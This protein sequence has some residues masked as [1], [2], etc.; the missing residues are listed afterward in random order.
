MAAPMGSCLTPPYIET[1]NAT[2]SA[3]L[4]SVLWG[5]RPQPPAASG[6]TWITSRTLIAST[7]TR[8]DSRRQLL[9][10]CAFVDRRSIARTAA[11]EDEYLG[12]LDLAQGGQSEH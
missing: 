6:S 5:S 11:E 8:V 1:T 10:C 2:V 4:S 7:A 9:A 3:R 12:W